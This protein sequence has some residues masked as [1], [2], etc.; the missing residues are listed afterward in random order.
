MV[1]VPEVGLV[2]P[3][4]IRNVVD[5]P[6]PLTP[7]KPVIE[8]GSR[9]KLR[10]STAV[11]APYRLVRWWTWM[12]GIALSFLE[13]GGS[14]NP[15]RG[16]DPG[17]LDEHQLGL[18]VL[19]VVSAA[20]GDDVGGA[21]LHGGQ[22]VLQLL[23]QPLLRVVQRSRRIVLAAMGDHGQRHA[24]QR[25]GSQSGPGLRLRSADVAPARG[26]A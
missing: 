26:A 15:G 20:G 3:S 13:V 12:R 16:D 8:P 6:A 2:R 1:A 21:G 23:P 24:A 14:A 19:D 22:L 17:H 11:T 7:T 25:V 18:L 5:L 10:S 9:L 4:S